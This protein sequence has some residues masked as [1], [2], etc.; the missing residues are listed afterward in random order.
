MAGRTRAR[1]RQQPPRHD[2]FT[3]AS[4]TAQASSAQ[5]LGLARMTH[6]SKQNA[7][8]DLSPFLKKYHRCTR[9]PTKAPASESSHTGT[10]LALPSSHGSECPRNTQSF[11]WVY[12]PSQC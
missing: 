5:H 10:A 1:P 6:L 9:T 12:G 7:G 8:P 11:D 4:A 2:V 3:T